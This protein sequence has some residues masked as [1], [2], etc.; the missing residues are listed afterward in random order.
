MSNIETQ[1]Y[2]L[3]YLI[4]P[5]VAEENLSA[6]VS[7]IKG[8]VN[9]AGGKEI[10]GEE[11][12]KTDLA[13]TMSK[14][15]GASR[16]VVTDAYIGWIKFEL[17]PSKAPEIAD[18]TNKI[19]EVLRH[20]LLKVPRETHFTFA[21]AREAIAAKLA[22]EKEAREEEREPALAEQAVIE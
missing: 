12:F 21:K 11:P 1:I 9:K 14:T 10:D 8:V 19:E 15:I 17:E 2:E 16:Y 6:A 20:I 3:G 4:L 5:S 18:E 7:K 13:Y 22:A